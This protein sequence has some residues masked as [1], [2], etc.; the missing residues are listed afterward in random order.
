MDVF[1]DIGFTLLGGPKLSPPKKIREILGL[2]DRHLTILSQ[3][4]FSENHESID[5][6]ISSIEESMAVEISKFQRDE[7]SEFWSRQFSDVYEIDG[8][9]SLLK[10][11]NYYQLNIHIVSNLWYPFYN[12]YKIIFR[13]LLKYIKTE[14]LSFKEGIRKPS[15]G[16]YDIAIKKAGALPFK[17]I[18]IGDSIGNDIIPCA[19]RGMSCVWFVSRPIDDQKLKNKRAYIS[20]YNNIFETNSLSETEYIVERILQNEFKKRT[21]N[22]NT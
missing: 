21:Q 9:S 18:M 3:I 8:A 4:I 20:K 17:S 11:L 22:Q 16:F 14:T 15:A 2:D 12:K 10:K 19:E 6:L 7:I 13:D 5:S 1:L